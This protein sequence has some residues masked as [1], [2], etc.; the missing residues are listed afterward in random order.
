[1]LNAPIRRLAAFTAIQWVWMGQGGA[2]GGVF[3]SPIFQMRKLRPAPVKSEAFK[4]GSALE[5]TKG[6]LIT[7]NLGREGKVTL[8]LTQV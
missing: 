5:P 7:Q 3:H 4:P 2:G 1:M 6:L 8:T